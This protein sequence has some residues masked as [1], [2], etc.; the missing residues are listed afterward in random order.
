MYAILSELDADSAVTVDMLWRRLCGAC[1]AKAIFNIPT[2]HFTWFSADELEIPTVSSI[3][4]QIAEKS[5]VLTTY[6]FGLGIFSGEFPVLYLPLVKSE[7][8]SKLHRQIWDQVYTYSQHPKKYY[9]AK[10][11]LPHI[12]LALNDLTQE[13]LGCALNSIAFEKIE[14][15][16]NVDNLM[17]AEYQGENSGKILEQYQFNG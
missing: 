3:L 10:F 15:N 17:I 5:T 4:A 11:W 8:M 1:G 9:A 14:L 2:P 13:N 16:I 12:T 6:A 7:Q